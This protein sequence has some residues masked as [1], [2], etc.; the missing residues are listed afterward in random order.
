MHIFKL[1]LTIASGY[2]A[3][4]FFQPQSTSNLSDLSSIPNISLIIKGI[5]IGVVIVSGLSFTVLLRTNLVFKRL[6]TIDESSIKPCPESDEV[7]NSFRDEGIIYSPSLNMIIENGCN[8]IILEQRRFAVH[9]VVKKFLPLFILRMPDSRLDTFDSKKVRLN[10]DLNKD[11]I[12]R[13]EVVQLQRTSY[14]CD[15]LSNSLASYE[16]SLD[17]RSVLNLRSEVI[18]NGE[19]VSLR[20]SQLSNQLGGSSILITRNGTITYLNQGNRTAENAGRPS[21]AGSGSFDFMKKSAI[22]SLTFQE[23]AKR[24][25]RRELIQECGLRESDIVDIQICG[26]GRYLYR[27]GKPEVF[28]ISSTYVDSNSIAPPIREWDYQQKMPMFE[29]INGLCNRENA[30]KGLRSLETKMQR[31]DGR[32]DNACGPLYW[33]V[34]FAV[35]YLNKMSPENEARL[36]PWVASK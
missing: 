20:A 22:E 8:P 9:P 6:R 35:E 23:Y 24:Q 11:F 12:E 13:S 15:R 25:T 31:R 2:V 26:F 28:C 27:N 3:F 1:T 10:S 7:I 34:I 14:F 21:P 29:T 16:L 17:G 18:E 4:V 33:N 30:V 5:S 19:L 32:L 36:F